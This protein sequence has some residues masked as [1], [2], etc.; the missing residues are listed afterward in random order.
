MHSYM[1]RLTERISI[2]SEVACS[3][4]PFTDLLFIAVVCFGVVL[5]RRISSAFGNN[6]CSYLWNRRDNCMIMSSE[7]LVL[8]YQTTQYHNP[9]VL[10][11]LK[12]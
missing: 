6:C 9:E 8:K 4:I 1:P 2:K 12:R 3:K 11:N 7:G 5:Y 10:S